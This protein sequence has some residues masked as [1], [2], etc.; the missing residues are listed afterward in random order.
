MIVQTIQ[1]L[2]S[3]HYSI[4]FMCS[5][6]ILILVILVSV[7]PSL[8]LTAKFNVVKK[9]KCTFEGP[10][11]HT[12]ITMFNVINYVHWLSAEKSGMWMAQ[13]NSL[14]QTW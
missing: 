10:H 3:P 4:G 7:P 1:K 11:F 9:R 2:L 5:F 8:L 6:T 12:T 14:G 13:E